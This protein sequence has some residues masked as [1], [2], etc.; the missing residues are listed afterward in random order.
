MCCNV[1]LETGDCPNNAVFN[2]VA[3]VTTK[4]WYH[5]PKYS[6]LSNAGA[7]L[8]VEPATESNIQPVPLDTATFNGVSIPPLNITTSGFACQDDDFGWCNADNG[9]PARCRAVTG[10]NVSLASPILGSNN[11][12]G[13]LL[14]YPGLACPAHDGGPLSAPD[15]G[16][17]GF[18]IMLGAGP[19]D[20]SLSGNTSEAIASYFVQIVDKLQAHGVYVDSLAAA[21]TEAVRQLPAASQTAATAPPKTTQASLK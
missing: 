8:Y 20:C 4:G 5:F 7:V 13:D 9:L 12:V 17:P 14:V 3:W 16:V 11:V 1:D 2:V 19:Y 6:L 18:G 21:V 15:N 10:Y